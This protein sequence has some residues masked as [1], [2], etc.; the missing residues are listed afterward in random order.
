MYDN[1]YIL[2]MKSLCV[3]YTTYSILRTSLSFI[4][5]EKFYYK[6]SEYNINEAIII[7]V[8]IHPIF[9]II[10]DADIGVFLIKE[11]FIDVT[12]RKMNWGSSSHP[13]SIDFI[14]LCAVLNGVFIINC[15]DR[16]TRN[17][18]IQEA[19]W[20]IFILNINDELF[21]DRYHLIE[22]PIIIRR[23][24]IIFMDDGINIFDNLLTGF[25][26]II[27]APV[28]VANDDNSNIGFIIGCS[29]V[30]N[31]WELIMIGVHIVIRLKRT[32]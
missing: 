19:Q 13:W 28:I 16:G 4:F 9:V 2:N 11:L 12:D 32:E 1:L 29:S 26:H 8:E 15:E 20:V 3:N 10:D 22:N 21:S 14:I 6:L 30:K 23:I 25:I 18:I 17:H 5:S 24:G 31:R 27:I 7:N